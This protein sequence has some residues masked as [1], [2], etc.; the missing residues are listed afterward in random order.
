MTNS[1]SQREVRSILIAS[2]HAIV[3]PLVVMMLVNL[4]VEGNY[5]FFCGISYL[6]IPTVVYYIEKE[7]KAIERE[8]FFSILG[9]AG[10]LFLF[11]FLLVAS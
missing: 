1:I 2:V 5:G 3:V 4:S 6:A 10:L 7:E 9:G 11:I 8:A